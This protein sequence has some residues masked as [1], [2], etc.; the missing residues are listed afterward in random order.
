MN[1]S[2]TEA[3]AERL[4]ALLKEEGGDAVVRIRE[5]KV[6]PPCKSKLMLRLS[7]D[8]RENDD[9]EENVRSLP[10]VISEDLAEQYGGN[11]SVTLD[12]HSIPVVEAAP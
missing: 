6:G 3:A 11:F 8:E 2:I 1:I 5:A 7:I 9:L 4:A 12:E 10:F